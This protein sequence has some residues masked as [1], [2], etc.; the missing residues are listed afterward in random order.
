MVSQDS[1]H[2]ITDPR[3][4]TDAMRMRNQDAVKHI[5]DAFEHSS[6]Q[7]SRDILWFS[8]CVA[9]RKPRAGAWLVHFIGV[10]GKVV[11]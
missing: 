9:F 7:T 11:L 6:S 3:A 8:C 4:L 2:G 1:F 10:S 5:K